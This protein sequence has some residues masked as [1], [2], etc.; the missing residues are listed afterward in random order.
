MATLQVPV[1]FDMSGDTIVFGE[2]AGA[3]FV[4]SHLDFSLD[5]TTGTTDISFNASDIS[6]AILV[7]D[8]ETSDG[9]FF[10]S[11]NQ[12]YTKGLSAVDKLCDRISKAI[13]M[14]K[15]VHLPKTGNTSNSGIPMGGRALRNANGTVDAN[16]AKFSMLIPF[17]YGEN[18][19]FIK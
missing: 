11:D 6:G 12:A 14:G 7:G 16:A 4:T 2:A 8:H 5:M 3:D 9:I 15:L 13:T 17:I 10:S 19:L 18:S 1:L